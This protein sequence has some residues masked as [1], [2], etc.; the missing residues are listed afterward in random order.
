MCYS[1]NVVIRAARRRAYNMLEAVLG[2]FMVAMIVVYS[3]TVWISHSKAVSKARY[4]MLG[5]FLAS[6]TLEECILKGIEGQT[7]DKVGT[8]VSLTAKVNGVVSQT[9]YTTFIDVFPPP[10]S[11]PIPPALRSV[12]VRVTWKDPNGNKRQVQVETLLAGTPP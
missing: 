5:L 8:V 1:L 2:S 9:D 12:R 4:E 7:E 6:Q 10:A 3:V 11:P